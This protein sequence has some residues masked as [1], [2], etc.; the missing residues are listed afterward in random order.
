MIL[1]EIR[2]TVVIL[3]EIRG[4]VLIFSE[5]RWTDV[6]LS[7]IRWTVVLSEI[8]WTVVILSEIRWTVVILSEIRWT[9]V[10]LSDVGGICPQINSINKHHQ[11]PPNGTMYYILLPG[12]LH[13]SLK[14]YLKTNF[15]GRL[16]LKCLQSENGNFYTKL[17]QRSF[18][19]ELLLFSGDKIIILEKFSKVSLY[20]TN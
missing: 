16:K 15:Y 20:P 9:V 4:T 13:S 7:E 6:L 3:S 11:T 12:L 10:I 1:S 2:K 8:R 19:L 17:K 14:L 18:C 5:I